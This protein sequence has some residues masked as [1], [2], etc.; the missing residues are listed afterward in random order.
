[1]MV[2]LIVIATTVNR[3]R[4]CQPESPYLK[5]IKHYSFF[6]KTRSA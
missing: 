4:C 6:S 2:N 5:F 3:E 1:M